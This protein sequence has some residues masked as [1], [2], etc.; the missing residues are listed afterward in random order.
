MGRSDAVKKDMFDGILES[1]RVANERNEFPQLADYPERVQKTLSLFYKIFSIP[2]SAVPS[3]KKLSQYK[4]WIVEL[5]ELNSICSP[6]TKME[7]VMRFGFNKYSKMNS[8][9]F[10]SRPIAIKSLVI[11]AMREI[12][13]DKTRQTVEQKREVFDPTASLVDPKK[14]RAMRKDNQ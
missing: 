1:A 5:D 6:E 9:F 2:V 7:K 10:I 11:D 13:D 3:K 14:F 12:K 8:K 4:E